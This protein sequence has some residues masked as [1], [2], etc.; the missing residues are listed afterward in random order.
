LYY[1][2]FIERRIVAMSGS[3]SAVTLDSTTVGETLYIQ[4]PGFNSPQQAIPSTLDGC[5]CSIETDNCDSDINM[6]T[7]Q[8]KLYPKLEK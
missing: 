5:T 6:Y 1:W 2:S 3:C 8:L 4:S 7:L